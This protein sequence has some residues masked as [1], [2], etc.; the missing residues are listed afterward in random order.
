MWK[1]NIIFAPTK[2][3]QTPQSQ[4]H[5]RVSSKKRIILNNIALNTSQNITDDQMIEK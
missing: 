3:P 1:S 2:V 4:K 5:R